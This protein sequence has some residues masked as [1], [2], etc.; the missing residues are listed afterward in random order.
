MPHVAG[1]QIVGAGRIGAFQKLVIAGILGNLQRMRRMNQPS[2]VLH[3]LQELLTEA[4]AD[5]E[6]PTCQDFS[7]VRGHGA[8]RLSRRGAGPVN[9]VNGMALY[10]R[11][12]ISGRE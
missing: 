3:Q 4:F 12:S 6:F 9:P 11:H 8:D 5:S 7:P 10:D 1:D 2:T